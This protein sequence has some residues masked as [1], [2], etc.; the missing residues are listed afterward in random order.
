MPVYSYRCNTCGT[1]GEVIAALADTPSPPSCEACRSEMK[2]EFSIS[3]INFNAKGFYR[4][5]S[6]K[7]N[8]S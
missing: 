4:S 5:D 6:G 8:V 1:T 2:R 3:Q 7:P